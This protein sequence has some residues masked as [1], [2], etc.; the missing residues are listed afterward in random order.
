MKELNEIIFFEEFET[1]N[2]DYLLSRGKSFLADLVKQNQPDKNGKAQECNQEYISSIFSF[3]WKLKQNEGMIPVRYK[4]GLNKSSGRNY[5]K[6]LG[7]QSIPRNIKNFIAMSNYT[8]Y[9][10]ENCH[11]ALLLYLAGKNKDISVSETVMLEDYVKNRDDILKNH[12]ITKTDV[13]KTLYK[14][15]AR[16]KN[17]YLKKFNIEL[18]NIKSKLKESTTT[19]TTNTDNPISSI[20]SQIINEVE[21]NILLSVYKKINTKMMSLCFDGFMCQEDISLDVLNELTK[22][23]GVVWKIKPTTSDIVVPEDFVYDKYQITMKTFEENNHKIHYPL[24]F[25]CKVDGEYREYNQVGLEQ[26]YNN[27]PRFEDNK[28]PFTRLWLRD[29]KIKCFDRVDFNPFNKD[30]DTTPPNIFN[31]FVPFSRLENTATE[32]KDDFIKNYF[33]VLLFNLCERDEEMALFLKK[34]IAHLIQYP[35]I[36]PETIVY[37]RGDQGIGKDTLIK[38]IAKLINNKTYSIVVD[39]P[40]RIF[41]RFNKDASEKL[42]ICI[43][44][45]SAQDAAEYENKIKSFSTK[46]VVD[47]ENKGIN[48]TSS[49]KN[50]AR[51]FVLSNNIRIVK[52]TSSSRR[53]FI[54]EGFAPSN[55]SEKCIKFWNELFTQLDDESVIDWLFH[56]LNN[57]DLTGF[58]P[59][60]FKRGKFY[61]SLMESNIPPIINFLKQIDCEYLDKYKDGSHLYTQSDFAKDYNEYCNEDN[62]GK[63]KLSNSYIETALNDVKQY[64]T[65]NKL[66]VNGKR[67]LCWK[68]NHTQLIKYIDNKYY[69]YHQETDS[70]D[71][72][73]I[74]KKKKKYACEIDDML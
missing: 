25:M 50:K 37:I 33:D 58:N 40:L 1:Y 74:I 49:V 29:P 19:T 51:V 5:C 71:E 27:M 9:D 48:G 20:I 43:N 38:I 35:N 4:H 31:T 70:L 60:V 44:E 26:L 8:D 18:K 21:S 64:I 11:F 66:T 53:E 57:L 2:I 55:D 28:I 10:M 62:T 36:Q 22:E 30:P 52:L 15:N 7:I 13:I 14:D 6:G 12:T 17:E 39:D 24:H 67:T 32:N 42:M 54:V 45:L 72:K 3:L 65:S 23:Y 69:K 68:F 73:D 46:E 59:K 56:H 63:R 16:P 61:S 41:G 34:Y 47:V